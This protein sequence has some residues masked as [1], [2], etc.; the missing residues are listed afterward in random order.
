MPNGTLMMGGANNFA[1]QK[2]KNKKTSKRV[3]ATTQ[4]GN[5]CALC[6]MV[7]GVLFLS[8]FLFG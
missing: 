7:W 1:K 3:R 8:F 5:I 2:A 4:S 6:Y